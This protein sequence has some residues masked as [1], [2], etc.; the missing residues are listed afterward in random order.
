M[1]DTKISLNQASFISSML[2]ERG[3]MDKFGLN[4]NRICE[5]SER[6][7]K[8]LLYFIYNNKKVELEEAL[9]NLK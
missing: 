3:L 9:K 2:T 8:R 1:S 6:E 5:L 4:F 7:Y